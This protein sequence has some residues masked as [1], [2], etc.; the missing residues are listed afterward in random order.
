[1]ADDFLNDLIADTAP[2]DEA[3]V[4]QET[5]AVQEPTP[6]TVQEPAA[7][8]IQPEVVERKD[9]WQVPGS[10]MLAERE[11]AQAA[12]R[13][14]AELEA[15]L[16]QY[17]SKPQEIPDPLDDPAGYQRH[18]D[19]Q[20]DQRL[21]A[22]RADMSYQFAVREHGKDKVEEARAWA[23]EKAKN[24]PIFNQQVGAVF[25]SEALPVD[26][27]VQQHQRDALLNQ[28][29]DPSKLDD[30]FQQEATKRGYALQSAPPAAAPVAV[31]PVTAQRQP[32]PPRSIA[33]DATP[34]NAKD[35]SEPASFSAIFQR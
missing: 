17:T 12:E 22:Q 1:M 32:A 16:T 18:F 13:R 35:P 28:I 2:A 27:V 19:A 15:Q 34:V 24:D 3:P 29:G 11:K 21:Q 4:V 7:A 20:L 33:A 10:A 14:A 23:I 26:W 5:E 9:P 25:Q 30:W 8:P 31:A 6:E